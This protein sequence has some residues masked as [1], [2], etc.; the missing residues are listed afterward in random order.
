MITPLEPG[1]PRRLGEYDL[2]GRLGEGGHGTVYLGVGPDGGRVA[3]KLFR[4]LT[5]PT[6]RQRL[7]REF[8]AFRRVDS[9]RV[10]RLISCEENRVVSEYVD[11]P[12]LEERVRTQGP[13]RGGELVRLAFETAAALADLQAARVL[14]RDLKPS[15]VLLGPDGPRLADFG[16][17]PLADDKGT[18]MSYVGTPGYFAPELVLTEIPTETTDVFSWAATVVHAAT[19]A[20]PFRAENVLLVCSRVLTDEPDLDGV[21]SE[22]RPLL[23]A[24]LDKDPAA[25][26]GVHA[27]LR[28]L[29]GLMAGS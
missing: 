18:P 22:L 7:A 6:G 4:T 11:G 2:V 13:L 29:R 3:V 14:H 8:E 27:L 16:V 12:S 20:H 19:G 21:P 5:D 23:R 10:V 25:R 24:C 15:N 28:N 17:L 9:P 1:D 26:P